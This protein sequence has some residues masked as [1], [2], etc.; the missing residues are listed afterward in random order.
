MIRV[1]N[2]VKSYGELRAVDGITF[3]AEP[4]EIFGLIGPNGAGKSTTIRMIMN[5]LVPDSGEILFDSKPL[6]ETDKRRIGYL[7]EERG[8]YRKVRVNDM[9]LYLGE[10]KGRDRQF[11]QKNIDA[12]LGKFGLTDWKN[13]KISEL[14]KG[15]AQKVQFIASVAHDPEILFFDEPFA[16]LDP[17]SVDTLRDSIVELSQNGKTILFSTHIMEQAEKLCSRIFLINKGKEVVYGRVEDIKAAHGKNSVVVEFDGDGSIFDTIEE[18][19]SISRFPRYVELDL[20]DGTDP[21]TVLLKIAGKI[22]ISRFEI[23]APSLHN[24]FVNL[25]GGKESTD[26]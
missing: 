20:A 8:L 25:V 2:V 24:M 14:S 1:E 21:D 17:V 7:P 15:M 11:L 18:V 19:V 26:E 9:L 4:G 13:K 5:I 22:S 3:A 16:G 12:W 6:S 23:V 10:L